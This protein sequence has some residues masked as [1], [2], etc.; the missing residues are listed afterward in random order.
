MG[1]DKL[2]AQVGHDHRSVQVRAEVALVL[3]TWLI[4]HATRILIIMLVP[5]P[6]G[7]SHAGGAAGDVPSTRWRDP[8]LAKRRGWAELLQQGSPVGHARSCNIPGVK[9]ISV[10]NHRLQRVR[11]VPALIAMALLVPLMVLVPP[12]APASATHLPDALPDLRM[13]KVTSAY[14]LKTTD[15]RKLLKFP[16]VVVNVGKGRFEARGY[17]SSTSDPTMDTRQRIYNTGGG[18]R[19]VA[20]NAVMRYA[21][22]GHNHW[23]VMNLQRFRLYRVGD[24]SH[25]GSGAK[26]GFCF[27]DNTKY[28]LSLAGAPD[29]AY[30]KGCGYPSNLSVRVGLSIGWGDTYPAAMSRQHIDVTRLSDGDYRL[31]QWAD[32]SN[33]FQEGSNDNNKAITY[34]RIKGTTVTILRVASGA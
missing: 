1:E 15:G 27:W 28:N 9:G 22:D 31:T 6:R 8:F 12:A 24:G 4:R 13:K 20:T 29:Y 16:S 26:T 10:I 3:L 30:Y 23:H 2:T 32:P 7:G 5:T 19:T 34:L 33:W 14:I 21:D 25:V 11:F 18:Y 17:R